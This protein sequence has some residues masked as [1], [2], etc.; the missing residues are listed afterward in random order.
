MSEITGAQIETLW[1]ALGNI[2]ESMLIEA[3][4]MQ[5]AQMGGNNWSRFCKDPVTWMAKLD[6]DQR[7]R[8]A[9]VVNRWAS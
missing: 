7:D 8:F 3:G 1:K 5:P 4:L 2:D 9:E 6:A